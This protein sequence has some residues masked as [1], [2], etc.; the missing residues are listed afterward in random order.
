MSETDW[1]RSGR[2]DDYTFHLVDPFTLQE[3]GETI[4]VEEGSG[5]VTWGWDTENGCSGSVKTVNAV[6]RN[7]LVRIRHAVAVPTPEGRESRV[8]TLG[9]F[10]IDDTPASARHGRAVRDLSLYSTMWRFTQDV[11]AR[12]FTRKKGYN[13]VQAVRDLVEDE[14]GLLI[15]KPGVDT[16]R[17]FGKE[18]WFEVA[19]NRAETMRTIAGWIGCVLYADEDGYIVMEPNV[20]A[21]EKESVYTFEA[22]G[23]CVYAPGVEI[24]DRSADAYNRVV[25]WWSRSSIPKTARKDADGKY[26]KDKDGNTV[27]DNDDPYG[28]SD[29]AYVDLP[30]H[31][32]FS[33][34]SIGRR[35]THVMK[36]AEA[37]SGAELKS[38]A[39]TWL[40]DNCGNTRYFE[41][42]HVGV[43]GVK[44]GDV[45]RYVNP[46][47][48]SE[49]IDVRC[50]VEEM[51][52]TLGKGAMCKTK[53]KEVVDVE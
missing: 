38:Q 47:D 36:V 14:G 23:N 7:K 44:V 48:Y 42:E 49:R 53:L 26:V 1:G 37:C 2:R 29:Y 3:T 28:L 22:G 4:E 8:E 43:P 18:V 31:H 15:V 52:M 41:I 27:Y 11:L 40:W 39:T 46:L 50:T 25:A 30:Y 13:V 45:V 32:A 20:T 12:D 21:N 10:F 34:E 17:G 35:K 16:A 6:T 33:Y 9:T 19:Q 24:G 5:N 51:S